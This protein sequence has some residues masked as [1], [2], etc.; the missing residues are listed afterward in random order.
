M[1]VFKSIEELAQATG[2]EI[3]VSDWV[4]IDQARVNAFADATGDHQWIHVDVERAKRE[5]PSK[6]TIVHGFLTLSLIPW[7]SSG[8]SRVEGV[9]RLLNYGLNKVRFPVA[10]ATG[11]RVRVRQKLISAVKRSGGTE[12]TMEMKVE[13]EGEERLGCIAELVS[14]AFPVG[15]ESVG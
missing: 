8:I 3:G 9:S 12:F 13:I 7:L 6:G 10:V 2:E 11:A 4:V 1:R 5:L 14:I 15:V